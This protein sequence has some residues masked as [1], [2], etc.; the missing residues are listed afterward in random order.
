MATVIAKQSFRPADRVV[1]R[2]KDKR[3][4]R[5][6]TVKGGSPWNSDDPVVKAHPE[7]FEPVDEK[8]PVRD[9]KSARPV[10]PADKGD[11]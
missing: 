7:Q 3:Q 8:T 4:V 1:G 9:H 6:Q 2:G 5:S 10:K 11:A